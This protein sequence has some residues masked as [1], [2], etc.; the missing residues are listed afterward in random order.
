MA[1]PSVMVPTPQA[2]VTVA[3]GENTGAGSEFYQRVAGNVFVVYSGV[4]YA[5]AQGILQTRQPDTDIAL[6]L[7]AYPKRIVGV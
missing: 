4:P 7:A 5:L 6:Q 1:V 3:M 2:T